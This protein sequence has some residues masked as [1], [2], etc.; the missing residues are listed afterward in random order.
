[1]G[2]RGGNSAAT[3]ATRNKNKVPYAVRQDVLELV[4]QLLQKCSLPTSAGKEEWDHYIS[5]YSL[6]QKIR[7][8]ETAYQFVP[9]VRE[10]NFDSFTKW[11]KT[12]GINTDKLEI[13]KFSH[14]D[15][16]LRATQDIKDD[17][18]FLSVPRNAMMTIESARKSCLGWLIEVDPLLKS[19]H[20]V[21]L[22]LHLLCERFSSSSAW[23]PYINILPAEFDTPPYFTPDELALLKGDETQDEAIRQYRHI[24]RQYAYFY[25]LFH[26]GND[27]KGIV[28]LKENFSYDAYRWAASAVMSRQN[29]IPSEDESRLISALIPFWD[30]CNHENGKISTD[31]NVELNRSECYALREFKAEEQVFIFYGMRTNAEFFIHSGFVYPCNMYDTVSV[32][33]GISKSDPLFNARGQILSKLGIPMQGTFYLENAE[34]PITPK[35]LAF[36][37]VFVMDSELVKVYCDWEDVL[38]LLNH[39]DSLPLETESRMWSF[40]ATRLRL[41]LCAYPTTLAEDE[42]K[43]AGESLSERSRLSL[44]MIGEHKRLLHRIAEI[45]DTRSNA[46]QNVSTVCDETDGATES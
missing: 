31:F 3:T 25:K 8:K 42:E 12:K 10:E 5:I 39:S 24:A 43:L 34:E 41:I 30:M 1:M 33:L 40:L 36:L 44:L 9:P 15:Y 26:T 35:L 38:S 11:L 2:R 45:A 16:G 29:M 27:V 46:A 6:V 14:G 13:A 32:K 23:G 37:R 28:F 22:T 19:M 4:E 20:N 7:E 17:E 21:T 18:M